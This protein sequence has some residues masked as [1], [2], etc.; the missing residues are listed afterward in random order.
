MKSTFGPTIQPESVPHPKHS[1]VTGTV[2]PTVDAH[3]TGS[4]YI[5]SQQYAALARKGRSHNHHRSSTTAQRGR[6]RYIDLDY[7]HP[8]EDWLANHLFRSALGWLAADRP[9][10]PYLK[11]IIE[12]YG[13]PQISRLDRLRF[14]L[15]HLLIRK[16]KGSV[17][18]EQFRRRVA[19]HRP[20]MRGL[21]NTA[22]SV[23][24]FGL[25][26]PQRFVAPLIIV[27]NFTQRCNLRCVH[28]YQSA[29]QAKQDGE[30][31]LSQRLAVVDQ[32]AQA[33]VPM[34]AF[35]GG[36]PTLEA[37]LLPVLRRCRQHG[38]HATIAT[39]G[40]TLSPQRVAQYADA[41]VRYF[42]VSLDCIDPARHD[43][44][45][46][47]DGAWQKAVEGLKN[48]AAHPDPNVRAGLAMCIHQENYHEVEDMIRLALD[49]K[50]CAFC[51]FNF[52][53]VG[54]GRGMTG[55]DLTP[56]QREW[57]LRR[58]NDLA[59]SRQIGVLS[60]APQFGRTCLV[61]AP[62]EGMVAASHLGAGGG[63]KARVVA[64]YVGGCGA[65]RCYMCI[66]PNG[67]CT[68]CVYM[69]TRTFGN[70]RTKPLVELFR[71]NPYWDLLCDRDRRA[72]HCQVCTF[73]HYCGGCRARADAYYDDMAHLDPGCLFNEPHW[74][75]LAAADEPHKPVGSTPS[76]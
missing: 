14:A 73:K 41:G 56:R 75:Q 54:R 42:E 1:P 45:R 11:R 23:A 16:F 69:P 32:A 66:Q 62:I 70:I 76:T 74:D 55:R 50:C 51:Y 47:S 39:N 8:L 28:C 2:E 33:H 46:G 9:A 25:T 52:I 72:G 22:Q 36:E 31:T 53:P 19:Q 35:A 40:T 24:K 59:Q 38:I 21:I 61:Y 68:P 3:T 67:D 4:N 58:L 5:H 49:L 57:L 63:E 71:H 20:T 44:F 7:H 10:G 64:K 48:V 60:T 6:Q 65:G 34:I 30:L 27:W 15:P 18:D 26:T 12:T 29:G 43:R 17:S 13:D 37:D